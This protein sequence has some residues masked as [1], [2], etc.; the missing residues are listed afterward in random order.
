MLPPTLVRRFALV[1]LVVVIAACLVALTPLVALA[2]LASALV[3]RWTGHGH[4]SRPLR[5]RSSRKRAKAS[6]SGRSPSR[7]RSD[8]KARSGR[9]RV[10]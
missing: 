10:T 8:T 6:E 4:R 7:C 2:S 5:R 1:P 3:R 9:R